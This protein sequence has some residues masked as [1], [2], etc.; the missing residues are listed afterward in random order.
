[1][2]SWTALAL[3][4]GGHVVAAVRLGLA[5]PAQGL[6]LSIQAAGGVVWCRGPDRAYLRRELRKKRPADPSLLAEQAHVAVSMILVALAGPLA[7]RLLAP[8]CLERAGDDSDYRLAAELVDVISLE[9]AQAERRMLLAV[10][11]AT[12]LVRASRVSIERV[13][14]ARDERV[15]VVVKERGGVDQ[16]DA[17]QPERLLLEDGFR[18]EQADVQNDLAGLGAWAVLESTP[19]P[20]AALRR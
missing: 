6:A 3:H 19:H 20:P 18:I 12:R 15:H 11:G 8:G 13:A 9:R 14:E 7:E 5:L 10:D 4:E 16:I 17:E 1:M 2:T